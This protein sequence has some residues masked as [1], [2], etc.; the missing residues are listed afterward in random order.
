MP[1]AVENVRVHQA[2]DTT[3]TVQ[4][5]T[6]KT[7][8]AGLLQYGHTPACPNK[9]ETPPGCFHTASLAGLKPGT[10]YFFRAGAPGSAAE[11][12]FAPYEMSADAKHDASAGAPPE[13]F[14]TADRR[15]SP[16]TF[17][18]AVTGD[19]AR[20][21]LSA[22]EAWRSIAHAAGQVRAGDTVLIHAGTYEEYVLVR[23]T[24]ERDLPITFRAAPGETVWM[25]G[26]R[27]FRTTAFQ[28]TATHHVHIDGIRFRHFR[29]E[30]HAGDV[31][32][33]FGGSDHVI[34]RSMHDGRETSG[35]V[36]NFLRAS[37]TS[38]LTVENCVMINGMGEGLTLG[39]CPE[40]T[41]RNCVFYNNFIRAL[42][43]FNFEP[44]QPV[45]LSHNLFCDTIPQ[46]TGN[47]FIRLNHLENLR[48]DHNAYFARLGPAERRV[49]ETAKIGGK[50]VGVQRPGTYRGADLLLADVQRQAGQEKGSLFGN[51][52]MRVVSDLLP[53]KTREPEWRKVEMHWDGNAF[54]AWDFADFM[55]GPTS[56]LAR[57]ADEKPIG[58]DPAAFR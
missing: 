33:V 7:T 45:T 54:G 4:W 46:K 51:P 49:V 10:K 44:G 37:G 40:A 43:V 5:W 26:S 11:L 52:G 3:A 12:R 39:N 30:S 20:S 34:R 8:V 21:G 58:L 35:Y 14:V 19:D 23:A 31:I 1:V 50:P 29:C 36:G 24:G 56:P 55:A 2:T 13:S 32:N 47:A 48:S 15:P 9:I 42:T 6:P 22:A 53:P 18:V 17:H 38:R 28:L 25:E 41:V 27:R 16:R 57:A